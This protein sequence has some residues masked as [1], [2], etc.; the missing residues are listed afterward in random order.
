MKLQDKVAV[1]TGAARGIGRAICERYAQ[2][3][4]FVFVTDRDEAGAQA[5]AAAIGDRAM[6]CGWT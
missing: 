3:G 5:V 6:G 4:A 1:V 2:E